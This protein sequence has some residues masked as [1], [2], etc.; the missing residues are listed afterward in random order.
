MR[1]LKEILKN[2]L[3]LLTILT[4]NWRPVVLMIF[5]SSSCRSGIKFDPQSYVGDYGTESIINRHG[6]RVMANEVFFN[7]FA[8]M[9]KD[10][11]MELRA[12]LKRAKLPR[13]TKRILEH[14]LEGIF[15]DGED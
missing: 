6:K 1:K 4:G 9:H 13:R 14:K 12:I 8:C 15:H 11:W 3:K 2:C 7:E 10:K 5:L